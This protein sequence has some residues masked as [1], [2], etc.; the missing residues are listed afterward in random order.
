MSG[1]NG[2][3]EVEGGLPAGLTTDVRALIEMMA[4]GGIA[5]LALETTAVKLRLRAYGASA[6][7]AA[8]AAHF[9]VPP[10]LDGAQ[11]ASAGGA[12]GVVITAPMLGTYYHA[13]APDEPPFVQVG[14]PVDAGQTIGI[15]E[16]MKIMNEIPSDAAGVVAE[17]F[18]VN[19]QP[20]EYGQPL[21]RLAPLDTE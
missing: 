8:E 2:K 20:V 21:L 5:D 16:A 9:A 13:P 1:S 7:P 11:T 3:A 19:G 10:A 17:I 18:V 14:D 4:R 15:I 12:E 6:R